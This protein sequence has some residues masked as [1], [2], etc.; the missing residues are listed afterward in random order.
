VYQ[1][2]FKSKE[3]E[4]LYLDEDQW[5]NMQTEILNTIVAVCFI[6]NTV[7]TILTNKVSSCSKKIQL[8]S[9]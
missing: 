1:N 8:P 3:I 2:V 5:D 6:P 9:K 4:D 7:G